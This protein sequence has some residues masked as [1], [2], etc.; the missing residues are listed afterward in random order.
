MACSGYAYSQVVNGVPV[1]SNT[2]P[3]QSQPANSHYTQTVNFSVPFVNYLQQ[4]GYDLGVVTNNLQSQLQSQG[5]TITNMTYSTPDV[6]TLKI[7]FDASSP[8]WLVVATIFVGLVALVAYLIIQI[9]ITITHSPVLQAIAIPLAVGIGAL[10][11]G[12]LILFLRGRK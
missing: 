7:D 9:I 8:A 5:H 4:A 3:T 2:S 1:C 6:N 10:A 11:V 12:G